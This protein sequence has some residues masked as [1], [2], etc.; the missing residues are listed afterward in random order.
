MDQ[1]G[2][3]GSAIRNEFIEK[4]HQDLDAIQ[5]LGHATSFTSINSQT[6]HAQ[7]LQ[8]FMTKIANQKIQTCKGLEVTNSQTMHAQI[9]EGPVT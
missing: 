7:I 1:V 4:S 3:T 2:L 8:K 5:Q 9:I 6:V